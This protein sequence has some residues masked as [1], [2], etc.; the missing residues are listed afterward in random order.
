MSAL[1]FSP[2]GTL[3]AAGC[4]DGTVRLWNPDTRRP[5]ATLHATTS[6]VYGVHAVAFSP[7][8]TLLATGEADGTVRAW[9]PATSQPVGAPFPTGNGPAGSVNVL[10][11]SPGG[12]LLAS[13]G[14]DGTVRL[15]QASL[16]AHAYPAL[17]ADVG[18]PT[19]QEW[20]HYASGEPQPKACA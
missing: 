3:L 5:V 19:P 8:G 2:D 10:A 16:F 17:C 4:G 1:A 12:R 14:D 11:F 7:D 9:N 18:P 20:N 13:G 6:S 15:W